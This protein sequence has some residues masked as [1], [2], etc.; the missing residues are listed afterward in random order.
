DRPPI[1]LAHHDGVSWLPIRHLIAAR[2]R[3]RENAPGQIRGN[4]SARWL[5]DVRIGHEGDAPSV[6]GNL[7]DRVSV[8][9]F[10]ASEV[11]VAAG[12]TTAPYAEQGVDLDDVLREER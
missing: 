5:R 6:L 11:A 7:A 8:E 3:R 10:A 2:R 1:A 4:A 12:E 9:P